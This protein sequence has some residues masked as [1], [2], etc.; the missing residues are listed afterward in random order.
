MLEVDGN[1]VTAHLPTFSHA[2]HSVN[3]LLAPADPQDCSIDTEW[4]GNQLK[5]R[6]RTIFTGISN[7]SEPGAV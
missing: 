6:W 1:D 3:L 4:T 5:T 2:P 7:F